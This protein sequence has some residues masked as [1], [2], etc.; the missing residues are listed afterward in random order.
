MTRDTS[1]AVYRQIKS[2]GLIDKLQLQVLEQL[3]KNGP[4]TQ[5]ETSRLIGALDHSIS[6]RFR[7]L[8][9]MDCIERVCKR[10][11]TITGRTVGAYDLTGRLPKR[12]SKQ[13]KLL[14]A[15]QK[16][17]QARDKYLKA[18]ETYY[19]LQENMGPRSWKQVTREC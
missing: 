14:E 15:Y 5:M 10:P 12:I 4:L 8:E 2:E 7:P 16:M 1:I 13:N 18:K 6:P 19:R 3:A 11:C 9:N 17:Q